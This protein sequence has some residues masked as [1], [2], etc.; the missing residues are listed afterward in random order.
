MPKLVILQGDRAGVDSTAE[1]FAER[2]NA[3][4]GYDIATTIKYSQ[5]V[6]DFVDSVCHV[7]VKSTGQS[8][9]DLADAY[10]VR[11]YQ[12]YQPERYAVA[13]YLHGRGK[14]VFNA[15]TLQ[16]E[17]LSKLEQLVA[18]TAQGIPVP[19]SRFASNPSLLE[20]FDYT[21]VAKSITSSNNRLNFLVHTETDYQG[22]IQTLG[23][24]VLLQQY[25]DN[26][27]DYKVMIVG[28]KPLAIYKRQEPNRYQ[29]GDKPLRNVVREDDV[30][31]LATKVVGV[32][33]RQFCGVDIVRD[34]Q[35]G[36]L[37]VLECNFNAGL[38]LNGID[39]DEEFFAGAAKL[40]QDL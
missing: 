38:R 23:D 26:D 4:A 40:L 18:L 10:Y 34:K 35:S 8:L 13:K 5:L 15:D 12:G 19:N 30:T 37:Y 24:K 36:R 22:A 16:G 9:E 20:P 29:P 17:S 21:F 14:K 31:A 3:N 25:V 39:V 1:L 33:N 32:L 11:D 6:F 2:L 27:G 28:G 7:T